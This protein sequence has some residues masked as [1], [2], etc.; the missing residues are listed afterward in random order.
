M[1]WNMKVDDAFV[2]FEHEGDGVIWI[3]ASKVVSLR[4]SIVNGVPHTTIF[5][6]GGWNPMVK[7]D[8][9]SVIRAFAEAFK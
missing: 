2:R 6:D 5:V 9:V 7:M 4:E 8:A 3:R 1:Q